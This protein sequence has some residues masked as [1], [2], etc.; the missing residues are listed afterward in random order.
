MILFPISKLSIS[1]NKREYMKLIDVFLMILVFTNLR[2]QQSKNENLIVIPLAK[3]ISQISEI[4]SSQFIDSFEYI[5]L[6]TN[7]KC[8]IGS[9]SKAIILNDLILIYKGNCCYIFDRKT[10]KYL[11]A[12][13]KYGRGPEEY[14]YSLMAF[15]LSNRIIYSMGWSNNLM[16]FRLDGKYLGS[17]PIPF[18]QGGL[19]APSLMFS[20]STLSNSLIV[21]YSTNILGPE[22]KL[23][24]IFNQKGEVIKLYPNKNIYPT[25]PLKVLSLLEAYFYNIGND[26]YFKERYNDTVFKVT[27]K[28]LIPHIVYELGQYSVPY[29]IKWKPIEELQNSKFIIVRQVF[30]NNSWIITKLTRENTDYVALFNKRTNKLSISPVIKDDIDNFIQFNPDY[31]DQ[32]G[33]LVSIVSAYDINRWFKG[34]TS[35]LSDRIK[36]LQNIDITQNPIVII[37]KTKIN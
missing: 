29:E 30:E 2:A 17:F 18:Q 23:L 10:G 20:F 14:R 11:Y 4:K 22:N 31:I 8:L 21:G 12:L 32:N 37:G 25:Q 28:S 36:G 1:V 33:N 19:E 3:N 15:D 13:S 24:T 6:E 26:T 27:V 16:M 9:D 7:E 35:K 5:Q 34:N